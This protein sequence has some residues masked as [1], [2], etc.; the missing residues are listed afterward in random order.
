MPATCA[1]GRDVFCHRRL[2]ADHHARAQPDVPGRA[3]LPRHHHVVVEH[4]AAGDADLRR[5]QDVAAD[6][7]AVGDLHEVV[8]LGAGADARLAD[9]RPI[10][11]RVRANLDVVVDDDAADLRDLPVRAVA[12]GARS[13]TRRCR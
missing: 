6:P 9:R 4:R 11:G 10:D 13:R 1:P 12:R 5:E 3:R 8:D 7:H 2:G